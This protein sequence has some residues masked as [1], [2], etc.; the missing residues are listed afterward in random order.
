MR[1]KTTI[2]LLI[3]AIFVLSF[4]MIAD[5]VCPNP[6]P[7]AIC[8]YEFV[9][10]TGGNEGA[11]DEIH[12]DC[13]NTG[14]TAGG[15]ISG[16]RHEY[17]LNATSGAAESSPDVIAPDTAPG[18]KRWILLYKVSG[19]NTGDN[20]VNSLYSGLATSKADVGQ[21]MYI[22]TTAHA[23]N[24]ASAAEALAGITS[25]TPGAD[26]S[27][28][29]NSVAAFK[30]E[31]SGA[32]AN[33]LYLKQGN[34]GIGTTTPSIKLQITDAGSAALRLHESGVGPSR[35]VRVNSAGLFEI[36]DVTAA[37]TRL[38]ID[39]NGRVGIGTASPAETLDVVGNVKASGSFISNS[40][41]GLS[42][43][44]VVKGS[45]GNN[46]NLVYTGGLLTSETCP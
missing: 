30:S 16:I 8:R 11:L 31:E 32:V 7:T 38:A 29:Q 14:D 22:G 13:L 28:T 23:I 33:T 12:G 36:Y 27:L 17:R 46:C 42:Q 3:S 19:T 24:R 34:V 10:L 45:D 9:E 15:I 26:F 1:G 43:T 6:C 44:V 35:D 37:T 18:T 40:L 25:L 39:A 5:A 4:A 21:T 20:A 2:I 41:T